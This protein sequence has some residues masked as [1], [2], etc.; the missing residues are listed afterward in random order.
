MSF[1][2]E[3]IQIRRDICGDCGEGCQID[4]AD[5]CAA[6]YRHIWHTWSG[7]AQGVR[8]APA[9]VANPPAQPV[10]RPRS[11]FRTLRAWHRMGIKLVGRMERRARAAHCRPGEGPACPNA[12]VDAITGLPACRG[13]CGCGA[14]GVTIYRRDAGCVVGFFK[15]LDSLKNS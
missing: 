3:D 6:C 7:C 5:P 13:G 14:A 4:H 1:H 11:I 2:P 9:P 10:A 12:A 8:P 15:P